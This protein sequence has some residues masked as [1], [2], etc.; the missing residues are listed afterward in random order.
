MLNP[1]FPTL[2]AISILRPCCLYLEGD[3]YDPTRDDA[4]E[5]MELHGRIAEFQK[6]ALF[7]PYDDCLVVYHDI[8]LSEDQHAALTL[9]HTSTKTWAL[10]H[11]SNVL[12]TK[13]ED[14][15]KQ[16]VTAA[17][18]LI[19]Q[20]GSQS[21]GGGSSTDKVKRY[22]VQLAKADKGDIVK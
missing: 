11:I 2:F 5:A 15:P 3:V 9:V 7:S 14:D 20:M 10:G 4:D 8:D 13:L 16:L 1:Y 12:M 6:L 18:T 21:G 17:T 22:I 19:Q